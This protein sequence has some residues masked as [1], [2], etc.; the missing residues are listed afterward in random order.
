MKFS[1]QLLPFHF[2]YVSCNSVSIFD[3][4]CKYYSGNCSFNGTATVTLS[5]EGAADATV[6]ITQ[7]AKTTGDEPSTEGFVLVPSLDEVTTGE[8]MIAAKVGDVY[9]AMNNTLSTASGS[10]VSVNSDMILLENAE[11][12]VFA[13]TR[14]GDV[15]TIKGG[16][17]K[18]LAVSSSSLDLKLQTS[19]YDWSLG[20]GDVVG[21]GKFKLVAS[22][23]VE[24]GLHFRAS[25][26]LV[27]KGFKSSNVTSGS[28]YYNIELFK[29]VTS[30]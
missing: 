3:G 2:K 19:S 20:L 30:N 6:T 26:Y 23:K 5:Y 22:N 24:Y 18:W 4:C 11:G 12:Y 15:V 10:I 14:I 21:K 27:F 7:A 16:G 13:I 28:A 17:D 1:F 9:Y 29:K 8:Y 25:S